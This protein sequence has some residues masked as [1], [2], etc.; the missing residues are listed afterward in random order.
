LEG[1]LCGSETPCSIEPTRATDGMCC[2]GTC[3][4]PSSGGSAGKIIGIILLIVIIGAVIWFYLKKYK[5]V[6]KPI[7]LLK[8]SKVKGASSEEI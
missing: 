4:N 5:G 6:K 2:K 3:N 1:I 8:I 7:D